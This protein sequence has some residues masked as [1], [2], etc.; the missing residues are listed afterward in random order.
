M[1]AKR[2]LELR[3][4]HGKGPMAKSKRATPTTPNAIYQAYRDDAD[5]K[6]MLVQKAEATKGVLMFVSEA[7]RSLLA[8]GHFV[9]L[10]RAEHLDTLPRNLA[11][12]IR[13]SEA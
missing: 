9:A 6:Q 5:R 11:S 1:Y 4:K 13:S 8:D 10:L 12:R 2:L 7:M 3:L